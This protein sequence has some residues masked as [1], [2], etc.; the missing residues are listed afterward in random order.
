MATANLTVVSTDTSGSPV[1]GLRVVIDDSSGIMI[2]EGFTPFTYP[3]TIG[4]SYIVV[5]E[6]YP[7]Y[8]FE[9]WSNGSTSPDYPI[10]VQ[11]ATTLTAIY[12]VASVPISVE[13]VNAATGLAIS[14]LR[15]VILN[16]AGNT[17]ITEGFTPFN[18]NATSGVPII[19]QVDNYDGYTF[20]DWQNGSTSPQF[21]ITP[22]VA[23]TL[24]AYYNV[25]T[26][27]PPTSGKGLYIPI[28]ID[29]ST[30]MAAYTTLASAISGSGVPCVAIINP[31]SG[32][33]SAKDQNYVT[34]IQTL[35]GAGIKVIGY[36]PTGYGSI[37]ESSIEQ[38]QI[39]PYNEFYA[40]AGLSGVFFDQMPSATGFESTY[41]ALAKYAKSLTGFNLVTGNPGTQIAPTYIGIGIDFL[42]IYEDPGMP[43]LSTLA[44]RTAG[45]P[46]SDFSYIA[47]QVSPIPSA[48]AISESLQYVNW[49]YVTDG[50]G[51]NES[52]AYHS[53]PSY[54]TSLVSL[55]KT[56]TPTVVTISGVKIAAAGVGIAGAIAMAGA[57]FA[58]QRKL[59]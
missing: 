51:G 27:P 28:Y 11:A 23:T 18:Y 53:L 1:T 4:T 49:V 30:N 22:T 48:T 20:S 14:G 56:S 8:T 33:G 29:P 31:A 59:M 50:P 43:S 36:V 7:P 40:S 19:V 35:V 16:S 25:V 17:I 10:T 44:N 6:N 46:S 32:A 34:A 2:T 42:N 9:K 55:L 52:G 5:V 26:P 54:L 41:A 38:T 21:P 24:T 39:L 12:T 3:A 13:S 37:S 15:T 57:A 58:K 47:Y 45:F